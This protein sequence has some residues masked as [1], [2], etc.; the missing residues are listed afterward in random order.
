LWFATK[1]YPVLPLHSI[2]ESNTCTCG[3]SGCQSPGKHPY[4]EFTPHGVKDAITDVDTVRAWFDERYWLNYG[5]ATDGLLVID[6][7]VKHNGLETW[8]S[9]YM[10]PTRALPHTWTARTGSGGLHVLFDN[11]EAKIRNGELDK[12]VDLRGIGGYI[13]GPYS[14][15]VSGGTYKW[16][17]QSAPGEAPL[18]APPQSGYLALSRTA[19]IAAVRDPSRNGAASPRSVLPTAHVIRRSCNSPAS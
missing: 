4:A 14:K 6:V 7:D 18:A 17:P 11:T 3:K 13:V 10:Q 12:G 16:L 5:V 2:T 8:Q 19:P 9:M 15:H 1:G